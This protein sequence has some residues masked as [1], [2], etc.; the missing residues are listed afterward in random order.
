MDQLSSLLLSA[1]SMDDSGLPVVQ[2]G[3]HGPLATSTPV[4]VS[5]HDQNP[6]QDD[7]YHE[8]I[9]GIP[10]SS[11]YPTLAAISSDQ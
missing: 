9:Q 3:S 5:A 10:Q 8:I 7:T 6:Q 1:L 11:L 2:Y 4:S